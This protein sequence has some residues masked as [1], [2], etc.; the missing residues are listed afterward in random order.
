MTELCRV[1]ES[2]TDIDLRL[3][4]ILGTGTIADGR[5]SLDELRS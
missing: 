4:A 5:L 2:S 1:V 3:A